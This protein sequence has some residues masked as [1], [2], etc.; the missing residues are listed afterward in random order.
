MARPEI[1]GDWVMG[2]PD[3]KRPGLIAGKDSQGRVINGRAP[4]TEL[5]GLIT[6]TDAY[7]VVDQ[8]E[9][10]DP[11]HPDDWSLTIGGEVE[12]P[13]QMSLKD[14]Q[15][16]PGGTVRAVTECA[17]VADRAY[18]QDGD[19]RPVFQRRHFRGR[20]PHGRLRQC[21][22]HRRHQHRSRSRDIQGGKVWHC[23]RPSQGRARARERSLGARAEPLM[24]EKRRRHP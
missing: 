6:P 13:I 18:R 11:V 15:K 14:L 21:E 19:T 22:N 8:L 2:W 9:V 12:H 20:S 4:I 7:Y 10:L 24:F 1:E 5:E 17:G 16:L 23:R 3:R